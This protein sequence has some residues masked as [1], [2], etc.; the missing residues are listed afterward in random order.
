[1]DIKRLNFWQFA[2]RI[3]YYWHLIVAVPIFILLA[4]SVPFFIIILTIGFIWTI[5]SEYN[6]YLEFMDIAESDDCDL[7]ISKIKA[8]GQVPGYEIGADCSI[9]IKKDVIFW[10][11]F[12]TKSR[13]VRGLSFCLEFNTF[14]RP[15][16]I[17]NGDYLIRLPVG[18]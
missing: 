12:K 11:N 14:E 10:C 15:V 9:V 16:S 8:S 18:K 4:V 2:L 7:F 5:V 6:E 1:M 17:I 13:G 3:G